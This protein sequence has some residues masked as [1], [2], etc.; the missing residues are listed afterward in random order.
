MWLVREM[1]G[2]ACGSMRGCTTVVGGGYSAWSPARQIP[3]RVVTK[4]WP[5]NLSDK[6]E[7]RIRDVST[8]WLR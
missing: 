8:C 6:R 4:G 1:S 3:T 2:R 7:E 5:V